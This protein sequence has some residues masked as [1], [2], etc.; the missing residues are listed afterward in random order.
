MPQRR[1]TASSRLAE[2][3]RARREAILEDW[4]A[5]VRARHGQARQIS[6]VA[7]RDHV[8]ELLDRIV[9]LLEHPTERGVE[10]FMAEP[11]TEHT[12]QRLELGFGLEQ[13]LSEYGLFRRAILGSGNRRERA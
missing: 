9:D 7:L 5:R 6:S 2:Q 4:Q 11:A 8:P 3:L 10:R 12:L 13:V 1:S